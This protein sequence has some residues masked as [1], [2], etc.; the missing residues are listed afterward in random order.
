MSNDFYM[1]LAG[2]RLTT[3]QIFYHMPDHPSVLQEFI[4]QHYDLAP[5]FPKLHDFL[6]FWTKE[7]DGKLHSVYVAKKELIKPS[8]T[9]FCDIELMLQ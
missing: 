7:I 3:A 2:Y 6:G 4:W 9:Q 1:E 5:K 8:K